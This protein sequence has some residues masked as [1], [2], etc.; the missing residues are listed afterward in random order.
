MD[1]RDGSDSFLSVL[2]FH[3]RLAI[4]HSLRKRTEPER[5]ASICYPD[6]PCGHS[7]I[8]HQPPLTKRP[9]C[10]ASTK[11]LPGETAVIPSPSL[12]GAESCRRRRCSHT[13]GNIRNRS[14]HILDD[15]TSSPQR[16][17]HSLRGQPKCTGVGELKM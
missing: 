17:L 1:C 6:R 5:R 12:E 8:A 11:E 14:H 9:W 16:R 13:L 3:Y 10:V 4:H 2:D 15:G 7:G